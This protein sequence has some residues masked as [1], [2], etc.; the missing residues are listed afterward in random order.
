MAITS[1]D[2]AVAEFDGIELKGV[3][4]IHLTQ[5]PE[6][7]LRVEAD[8]ETIDKIVP[9]VQGDRLHSDPRDRA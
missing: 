2:R 9:D 6:T 1:Q 8:T 5:G 3:G 7:M 4:T